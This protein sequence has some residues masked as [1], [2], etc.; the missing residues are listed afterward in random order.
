[1][2]RLFY[3]D[4]RAMLRER[5][6]F[7]AAALFAYA[8][9]VMP[10][11]FSK[12]P[13]HLVSAVEG[14]FRTTD[15]FALF[16]YMWTDL[17]MNKLAAVVAIVVAGGLWARERDMGVLPVLLSKPITPARYFLVRLA[18]AWATLATLYVGAHLAGALLFW[19]TI[20]GFRPGPF[21]A[22]MS[23]HLFTLLFSAALAAAF[24]VSI[25]KRAFAMVISLLVL[26][27]LVGFSFIGFYQPAWAAASLVN[28][29]S[30]GVQALGHIGS[31]SPLHVLA[32]M[33]G[34]IALT[35]TAAGAGALA[36]RRLEV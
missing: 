9:L 36:A 32:P 4:Y 31:L 3:L 28:P 12:P 6:V 20:D 18:A 10:V 11:L 1:M 26:L 24:A 22:S 8:V 35:L 21:F 13:P 29:F 27:S 23:L 2:I 34:L 19:R 17:A 5:K 16:L 30:L 15:R 25:K 33:A 7:V 14:W